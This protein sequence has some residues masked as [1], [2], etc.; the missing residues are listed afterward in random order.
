MNNNCEVIMEERPII[1]EKKCTLCGRCVFVCPKEVLSIENKKLIVNENDCML[2]SHC[3]DVCKFN[4]VSFQ[5]ALRNI[6]FDTFKYKEKI[7]GPKDVTPQE[8]VNIF[9][10]RRSIRRFKE[11]EVGDDVVRDL[12]EFAVTAP[13]G[14]NCQEWEFVVLNGREKVWNFAVSIRDFF[15]K[16]N[17]LAKNPI[18]RYLS[19]PFMGKALINYYR[20]HY[21]TVEMAIK[22]SYQ[23]RDLLFHGAP[24]IIIIHSSMDGST[25]IEDGTYAAYNICMLAHYMGYGTCLIG[26][27][28]EAL[29]RSPELK[30][31][32]DISDNRV[33]AVIA[34]GKPDV[35]FL[36]HSLRKDYAV[37]FL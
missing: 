3:Y 35:K 7:L 2:C 25:P 22:E 27:A 8:I 10:S 34:L 29:N 11:E 30:E 32:L 36:K 17:K 9:R 23:G 37:E 5:D 16:I 1:D 20:D 24:C 13:S 33:H 15:M 31:A 4:A 18:I 28:V 14:S 6:K 12:I 19:V 26:F 21:E